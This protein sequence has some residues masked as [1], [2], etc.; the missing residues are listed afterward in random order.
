MCDVPSSLP[1]NLLLG[2]I[3]TTCDSN[4]EMIE[5][6]W[7]DCDPGYREFLGGFIFLS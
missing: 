4:N 3:E 2:N 6:C 5:N 1:P 7:I